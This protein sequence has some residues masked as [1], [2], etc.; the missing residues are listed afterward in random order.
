MCSIDIDESNI[1]IILNKNELK[2]VLFIYNEWN[3]IMNGIRTPN[4]VLPLIRQICMYKASMPY[5]ITD[6]KP[7]LVKDKE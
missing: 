1:M 4:I 6:I 7:V 3:F 5:K 2:N